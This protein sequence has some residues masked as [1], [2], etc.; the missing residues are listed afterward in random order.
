M[1][2]ITIHYNNELKAFLECEPS[3]SYEISEAFAFFVKGYKF[4]PAYKAG[5]WDG[6]I[7][8]YSIKDRQF[9][10]GLM[11]NLVQWCEENGYTIAYAN[12]TDF[13]NSFTEIN[14]EQW[15]ELLTKG[16]YEPRWYQENAVKYALTNSKSLILSPTGSGKSYIIYLII[17]HLL[18]YYEGDILIV[19]PSTGLVEQ[20]F[21]D[22]SEYVTDGWDVEENVHRLYGGKE[23]YL[24]KRV[25]ISTWQTARLLPKSWFE[26]FQSYICDE[27]HEADSK[28]QSAI[29]DQM[30][31]ARFRL[32]LT[33]TLDGTAMHELEMQARFGSIYVAAKTKALQDEGALAQLKIECL[34]L[35]YTKEEID[36]VKHLDYQQEIAFIVGHKKRNYLLAKAA[37]DCDGNT[38]MLFNFIEKHGM[39]LYEMLKPMCE[40]AGKKLYYISGNVD[41]DEREKIRMILEKEDNCILL[42]S[43]GTTKRGV[44]F[45]N[46]DNLIFCHPFKATITILQ[47]IGRSLR[48]NAKKLYARLIDICDDFSYTTKKGTKKQN[49]T[50]RHFLERLKTYVNEKWNYKIIQ[51]QM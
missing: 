31:H 2:D 4:M 8:L 13:A 18:E 47:S 41:V 10:I 23:K 22:F 16:K 14:D 25:T 3:I 9:Y 11:Q 44:N 36:L 46:L 37:I 7:R 40:K 28:C 38:L 32:G 12:K 19:V 15:A 17:R 20:L 27:A 24:N 21:G 6:K 43:F 45:K 48:P 39:I 50:L 34:Q 5:R 30:A 42:A 29:I 26:R 35:R 1:T 51:I 49:T 33:G